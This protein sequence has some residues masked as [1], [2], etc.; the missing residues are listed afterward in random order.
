VDFRAY[1]RALEIR[2]SP[3]EKFVCSI[4]AWHKNPETGDC[5]PSIRTLASESGFSIQGVLN[6]LERLERD[7]LIAIRRSKG[8]KYCPH[9]Y[10]LLFANVQPGRTF[11][12]S[13]TFNLV[14]TNV[15]PGTR[16]RSTPLN[17]SRSEVKEQIEEKYARRRD[18]QDREQLDALRR[19][20]TSVK[21][22]G[23]KMRIQ[24][25]ISR[26]EARSK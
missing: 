6:I 24:D 17:R 25:E 2:R 3:P 20:L 10:G 19:H 5:F 23:E 9:H 1:R 26:L 11:P 13:Q 4:L 21:I 8:G 22:P 16:K 14:R 7:G 12:E 15:Q 18:R